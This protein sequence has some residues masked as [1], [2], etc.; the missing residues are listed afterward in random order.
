MNIFL[1]N[2]SI[3]S[4]RRTVYQLN[5][6]GL[7]RLHCRVCRQI[8]NRIT[9]FRDSAQVGIDCRIVGWHDLLESQTVGKISLS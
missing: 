2:H 4:K 7:R 1:L 9:N 5:Q 6:R 8:R 3:D